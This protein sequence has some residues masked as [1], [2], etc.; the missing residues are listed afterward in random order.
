M[1]TNNK[2]KESNATNP[3]T[4]K[5]PVKKQAT[6]PVSAKP[7]VKPSEASCEA[8]AT[9]AK[10]PETKTPGC[11][12]SLFWTAENDLLVQLRPPLEF[13]TTTTVPTAESIKI[14][15]DEPIVST[16]EVTT[17]VKS[18]IRVGRIISVP[19]HLREKYQ[20][21]D[22][23]AFDSTR[24]AKILDYDKDKALVSPYSIVAKIQ[25]GFVISSRP[26][27]QKELNKVKDEL[28]KPSSDNPFRRIMQR[29]SIWLGSHNVL[30]KRKG[31]DMRKGA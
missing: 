23:I 8:Q 16:K 20:Y 7:S 3:E 26:A 30:W 4:Q 1:K 15:R 11:Y 19:T 13:K 24:G 2:N 14:D 29:F 22:L 28:S 18:V 25:E 9:A 17:T 27:T 31:G 12:N 10:E 21:K 6:T 5:A